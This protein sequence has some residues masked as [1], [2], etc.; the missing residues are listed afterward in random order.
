MISI[1]VDI[2]QKR[3]P[4]AIA[5]AEIDRRRAAPDRHETHFLIRYLG[6]LPLG[7]PYPEVARRVAEV[8]E[9]A[10]SQG[11]VS[12]TLYLDA[13]GVGQPVVDLV[14]ERWRGGRPI[15]VYFTHGD[16]RWS[17]GTAGCWRF[18]ARTPPPAGQHRRRAREP[19]RRPAE[20]PLG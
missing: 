3:D 11:G 2:G 5:V 4:T 16:C 6:R 12:A 10:G 7:T 14:A 13:T 15:A 18:E 20:A 1:G 17:S 19:R 9:R 8:A